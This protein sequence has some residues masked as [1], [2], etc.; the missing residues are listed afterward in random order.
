MGDRL[1]GV[2]IWSNGSVYSAY[3]L[4]DR[5]SEI[6]S[7]DRSIRGTKSGRISFSLGL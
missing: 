5:I 7:S 2:W 1:V 3:E 4:G 6:S